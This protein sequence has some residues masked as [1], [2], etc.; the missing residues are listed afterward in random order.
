[1]NTCLLTNDYEV[2]KDVAL[3]HVATDAR[4][5]CSVRLDTTVEDMGFE[6]CFSSL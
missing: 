2:L 5:H 4:K 1:M 6:K 3:V